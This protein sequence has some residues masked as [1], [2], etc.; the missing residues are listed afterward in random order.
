MIWALASVL[1]N[2]SSQNNALREDV[3]FVMVESFDSH[4]T[5]AHLHLN[6]TVQQHWGQ[7]CLLYILLIV[8]S[9]DSVCCFKFPGV[10]QQQLEEH[11]AMLMSVCAYV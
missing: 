5:D 4:A 2:A 9:L 8:F 1:T 11:C 3:V 10:L 6:L 7:M